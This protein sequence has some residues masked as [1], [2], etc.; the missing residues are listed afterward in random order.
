MKTISKSLRNKIL[1]YSALTVLGLIFLATGI[2]YG[3][4]SSN[5][6]VTGLQ[7]L[8]PA[9]LVGSR[10]ISIYDWNEY[11]SVAMAA[12][13]ADKAY[14]QLIKAKEE[15]NVADKLHVRFDADIVQRELNYYKSENPEEYNQTLQKFFNGQEALFVKYFVEP[16]IY[17]SALRIKYNADLTE[18]LAEYNR[19]QDILNKIKQGSKFED[20]AKTASDDK[21]TGQL[22]GDLGFAPLESFLPELQGDIKSSSLGTPLSYIVPSRFGYHVLYPVE[23]ADKDGQKLWH[24]KHILVATDGYDQWLNLQLKKVWVWQI[25]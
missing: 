21:L 7:R 1:L 24:V 17:D 19:A 8:Y 9:A 23:T 15:A 12:G 13:D 4:N 11:R 22:G 3:L 2:A 25:K 20:L 6:I 16:Q 5:S 18:N 14:G 10:M